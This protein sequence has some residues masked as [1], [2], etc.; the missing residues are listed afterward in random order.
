VGAR[1][2]RRAERPTRGGRRN[3]GEPG[4][5]RALQLIWTSAPGCVSRGAGGA[6]PWLQFRLARRLRVAGSRSPPGSTTRGSYQ[7]VPARIKRPSNPAPR[8][9]VPSNRREASGW[10]PRHRVRAPFAT[11]LS[12]SISRVTSTSSVTTSAAACQRLRH[13][14]RAREARGSGVSACARPDRVPPPLHRPSGREYPSPDATS[15]GDGGRPAASRARGTH[16]L[17]CCGT[18]WSDPPTQSR[19]SRPGSPASSSD[20]VRL[21]PRKN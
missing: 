18:P 2:G 14:A 12:K 19:R 4:R 9:R 17:S 1:A 5:S 7:H 20:A 11:S 15:R 16:R 21:V 8:C 6:L 3:G 13:R 10:V